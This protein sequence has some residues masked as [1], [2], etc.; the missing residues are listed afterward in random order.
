MRR[1]YNLYSTI[2]NLQHFSQSNNSAAVKMDSD[3]DDP[4]PGARSPR[5]VRPPPPR[6]KAQ[7]Q[8]SLQKSRHANP[9]LQSFASQTQGS[10]PSQQPWASSSQQE[11]R[12]GRSWEDQQKISQ[13][14]E[15]LGPQSFA[16]QTQTRTSPAQQSWVRSPSRG[17][18]GRPD[19][20][21]HGLLLQRLQMPQRQGSNKDRKLI[22]SSRRPKAWASQQE[23]QVESTM[24]EQR[25][26]AASSSQ[27]GLQ[28]QGQEPRRQIL[29][30]TSPRQPA[31]RAR[32]FHP[33]GCRC[34]RHRPD[35]WQPDGKHLKDTAVV[36]GHCVVGC[37]C[38]LCRN[39]K[40]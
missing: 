7:E 2:S 4:V 14:Q 32:D 37:R 17:G 16:S 12:T 21:E 3:S 22:A 15:R 9:Q 28:Q 33:P 25:Q 13:N 35:L 23:R 27:Q 1:V 5:P 24:E 10:V 38:V 19:P 6:R 8:V 30:P 20:A 39:R 40:R 34:E 36:W 26:R 18:G 29:L 31:D 11:R